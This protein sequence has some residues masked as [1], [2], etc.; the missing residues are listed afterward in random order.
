MNTLSRK[1]MM[2]LIQ[3]NLEGYFGLRKDGV[4]HEDALMKLVKT[5]YLFFERGKR[6]K[7][8]TLWSE[9]KASKLRMNKTTS[10]REKDELR[11]L[12][13]YM[14]I[15]ELRLDKADMLTLETYN[16]EFSDKFNGLFESIKAKYL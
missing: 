4:S 9:A 11:D 8:M 5:R 6:D 14:Y 1:A 12:L 15:V 10:P 16:L 3:V 7:V 13:G 2:N